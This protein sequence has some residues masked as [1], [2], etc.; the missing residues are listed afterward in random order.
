MTTNE[1]CAHAWGAWCPIEE[2]LYEERVCEKCGVIEGR[3]KRQERKRVLS[4]F[5]S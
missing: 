2:T 4:S 1:K 3:M 5:K